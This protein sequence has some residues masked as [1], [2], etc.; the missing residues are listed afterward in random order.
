MAHPTTNGGMQNESSVGIFAYTL[1]ARYAQ[2]ALCKKKD[3]AS[4][5]S[6]K[7]IKGPLLV[8]QEI[9]CTFLSD[10]LNSPPQ[11]VS[12]NGPS[13]PYVGGEGGGS[14][15]SLLE[16][17]ADKLGFS[18]V[19]EKGPAWGSLEGEALCPMGT[20]FGQSEL[21]G[22]SLVLHSYYCTV[23]VH[24]FFLLQGSRKF[25]KVNSKSPAPPAGLLAGLR[26]LHPD[27]ST[28]ASC[29]PT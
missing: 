20:Q 4:E 6:R 12:A 8:G 22:Y 15:I 23:D 3:S 5:L 26:D 16:V 18:F 9:L 2:L 13:S 19:A 27:S 7:L 29:G 21:I 10:K 28:R 25:F 24:K 1:F 17:A 11:C 14:E